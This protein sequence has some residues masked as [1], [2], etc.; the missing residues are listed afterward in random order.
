LHELNR[1]QEAFD[2]LLPA[3]TKFSKE[4][5]IHYNLACYSAQLLKLDDAKEWF[6]KSMAID[7][8]AAKEHALED[9]DLQPLWDS[10]SGTLWKRTD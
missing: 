9:P 2:L 3:A 6:Q 1:T 5:T 8:T 10:M 7:E 4:W